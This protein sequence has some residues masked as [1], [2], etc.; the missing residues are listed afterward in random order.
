MSGPPKSPLGIFCD[1]ENCAV[2]KNANASDVAKRI[3]QHIQTAHPECGYAKEF[4]IAGDIRRMDAHVCES[5][6]RNGVVVVH[7]NSTAKNAADDKLKE[8]ID[9][10]VDKFGS[11]SVLVVITGDINFAQPIRGARRKEIAVVLIH[12]TSHSRDLKNLVDESY[13]FED[14]IKGC[15]TITKE[16]KQLNPAYLKVSNLPK[17]RSNASIVNRL[18]HLSANCGGKVEGVVSGE[19]VIR[20]GC[21]DDA[22]RALQRMAGK[23][24]LGRKIG[25]KLMDSAPKTPTK[26]SHPINDKPNTTDSKDSCKSV[27]KGLFTKKDENVTQLVRKLVKDW[28]DS[29]INP[30]IITFVNRGGKD[31]GK[32]TLFVTTTTAHNNHLLF[33]A[34]KKHLKEKDGIKWFKFIQKP[35]TNQ[36]EAKAE[37]KSQPNSPQFEENS[38]KSVLKGMETKKDDNVLRIVRELVKSWSDTTVNTTLIADVKRDKKFTQRDGKALL[39]VMAVNPESSIALVNAGNRHLKDGLQWSHYKPKARKDSEVDTESNA[40]DLDRNLL[41]KSSN[42][43]KHSLATPVSNASNESDNDMDRYLAEKASYESY[44]NQYPFCISATRKWS[45]QNWWFLTENP[46][47][48]AFKTPF[49]LTNTPFNTPEPMYYLTTT[50]Y[51]STQTPYYLSLYESNQTRYYSWDGFES[52]EPGCVLS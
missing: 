8:L 38:C 14:V 5:L 31:D 50:P 44:S 43:D 32:V 12:G 51:Y 11:D 37:A 1:I 48:S 52:E 16:E 29:Q 15:E 3:R 4:F 39:F 19:A 18:S 34:A 20:F 47:R 25:V 45:G 24:C 28:N 33:T 49:Y 40:S 6:D 46:K 21:K 36:N 26:G 27:I 13:L 42:D 22:Q 35:Q 30:N 2:P 41:T 10:F 23:D 7:V 17:E 9:M